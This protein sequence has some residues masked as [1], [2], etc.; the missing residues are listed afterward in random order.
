MTTTAA[1]AAARKTH[2]PR[3]R[4]RSSAEPVLAEPI[5]APPDPV[6]P[7]PASPDRVAPGPVAADPAEPVSGEPGPVAPVL[8]AVMSPRP[9]S[10]ARPAR[11]G[12]RPRRAG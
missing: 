5:P 11:G 1:V 4:G 7:V 6:A 3:R 8:G 12:G 10:A 9:R 2:T